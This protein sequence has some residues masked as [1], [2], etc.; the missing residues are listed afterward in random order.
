M[1]FTYQDH[2]TGTTLETY[3]WDNI[4]WEHAPDKETP[5]ILAIGDS[6]S[7]GWRGV[8]NR[9]LDGK[10]YVDG[11]GSSK[12]LDNPQLLPSIS[13]MASQQ[14]QCQ[15]VLFNNG[16]HGFHLTT[17]QYQAHYTTVLQMIKK[18]FAQQ[19]V[20]VLLTTPVYDV[21]VNPPVLAERT[22]LVTARNQAALEVA[23]SLDIPVIDLYT[24]VIS[25]PEHF[26][27]GVH[28]TEDGYTLL[29]NTILDAIK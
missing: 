17:G 16:L 6:I 23:A 21:A 7:C 24:A 2:V 10:M 5:R 12:A 15:I 1:P 29:A 20:F 8:L 27:D 9:I 11:F 13:L 25:H 3:E 19:K 14:P 18:Q 28:L 4:W 22:K 26:T